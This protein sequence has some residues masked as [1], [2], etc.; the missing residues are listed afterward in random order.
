M[1]IGERIKQLRTEKEITQTE[2]ADII[3]TTKQNI[4]KYE[5]GI[6]TNI[7][8]DK[9]EAISSYFQVSP[10]FLMGW[11]NSAPSE[12]ETLIRTSD[13]NFSSDETQHIKK[14]RTLDTYGKKI[15]DCV[16]DLEFERCKQI[17]ES[18]SVQS[19]AQSQSKQIQRNDTYRFSEQA[20]ARSSESN[21]K[22]APTE[23]QYN[24]FVD[25]P[26]DMLGE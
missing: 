8:S 2:L 23:E 6:I 5:N 15:I 21:Y 4:Y 13:N 3:G 26:D 25:L 17:Y 22:P 18:E 16:L 14:Y 9:I 10:A 1:T 12:S 24:E 7:P 19:N 11:N 20:I